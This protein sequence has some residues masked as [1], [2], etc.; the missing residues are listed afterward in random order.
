VWL[1]VV[2]TETEEAPDAPGV[3]TLREPLI[4]SADPRERLAGLAAL[5]LGLQLSAALYGYLHDI[6]FAGQPAVEDYKARAR[7]LRDSGA[8]PLPAQTAA[9][10]VSAGK[11][12][13]FAPSEMLAGAL[14]R[15][16]R[17]VLLAALRR[18]PALEPLPY[19]DITINGEAP[20]AALVRLHNSARPLAVGRLAVP[21][22]L[23]RAPAAYHSTEQSEMDGPPTLLSLRALALR[24]EPTL[25]GDYT[26]R[27]LIAQAVATWQAMI[28]VG[29]AC[30]LLLYDGDTAE[31]AE[32]LAA[33]L[34]EL[35]EELGV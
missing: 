4:A 11:W 22:K 24:H 29:R 12:T 16:P 5:F 10:S 3:F 27:F 30:L 23:R 6:P 18:L 14:E 15:T 20:A 7:T 31:M 13:L 34:D 8:D 32:A 9:N 25:L 21:Y 17:A 33:L 1:R 26:P 28:G 35:A 2:A 19:L